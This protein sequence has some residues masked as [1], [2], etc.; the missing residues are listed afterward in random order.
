MAAWVRDKNELQRSIEVKV[1]AMRGRAL[2]TGDERFTIFGAIN[3][4]IIDLSIERGLDA[5]KV[6]T[7]DTTVDTVAD[8]NYVD[9]GSS[10]IQVVDKTVRIV[11]EKIILTYFKGAISDFYRFDP[12]EDFSSTFPT[13]YAMDTDGSGTMRM[14]LRPT[15][16]AIYTIA[17]KIESIPDEDSI[18]T[19]PGWYHPALRSLSTAIAL[20]NLGLDGRADQARYNKRLMDIREKM[21]GRSGPQHIQMQQRT[22]RPIADELR[23]RGGIV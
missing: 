16:D 2:V 14:L 4:A 20:E 19:F 1:R 9:L 22:Y 7:T 3:E 11:A 13:Y 15:P 12:G 23:I 6:I 18:S 10:V 8:Q 21:R 17:L 5:P